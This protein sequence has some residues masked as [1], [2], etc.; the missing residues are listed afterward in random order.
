MF[1]L[2]YR[3]LYFRDDNLPDDVVPK[4]WGRQDHKEDILCLAYCEPNILISATYDGQII[5][6]DVEGEKKMIQMSAHDPASRKGS[7]IAMMSR[8][9]R[10]KSMDAMMCRLKRKNTLTRT[11]IASDLSSP[12]DAFSSSNKIATQSDATITTTSYSPLSHLK[13]NLSTPPIMTPPVTPVNNTPEP[14]EQ[15]PCGKQWN[16]SSQSCIDKAVEKVSLSTIKKNTRA[17]YT[18]KIHDV[19][20]RYIMGLS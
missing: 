14:I 15:K 18:I 4:Y 19:M 17:V 13:G 20:S 10:K 7:Q 8:H 16:K 1:S 6:W 2:C 9:I 11:S 12:Q 5:M 3:V